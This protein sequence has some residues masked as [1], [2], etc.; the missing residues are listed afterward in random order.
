MKVLH[1]LAT[2]RAEGTPNL[3]LDWLAA[4]DFEQDVFV[5][6]S[7]P[8]DLSENL[9]KTA[10]WYGE[11]NYFSDGIRKFINI[12]RGVFRVCRDRRPDVILC[13]PTGFANWVCLGA[14]LAGVRHLLV[15]AGNPP[16]RGIRGDVMSRY[17]LWPL[18]LLGGNV[19]CCSRYVMSQYQA[20]PWVPKRLFYAVWNCARSGSVRERAAKS[21]ALRQ[22]PD[23]HQRL[24]MVATLESHKDHPTLFRSLPHIVKKFPELRLILVGEGS[25]RNQ[26]EAQV[27]ALNIQEYVEFFGMR[28]DVPELLGTSDLFVFSTTSQEGLGTVLIEAMAA[29]LSIV[30]TDVPACREILSDGTYGTLVPPNDE[31]AMADAI[32]SHF[33][34]PSSRADKTDLF[35]YTCQFSAEEMIRKYLLISQGHGAES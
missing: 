20:V 35:R 25:L 19:I 2:P 27:A 10:A 16:T 32:I 14:R 9:E 11:S 34:K 15:H 17:V 12:A 28:N 31:L 6:H 30:A 7:Q 3:V 5:L 29:E 33:E 26:L 23:R 4:G 21:R 18:T 8:A 22:T 24:I 1:I 13:W